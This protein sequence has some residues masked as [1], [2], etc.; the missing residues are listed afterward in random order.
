MTVVVVASGTAAVVAETTATALG[1][2]GTAGV[3]SSGKQG[4]SSGSSGKSSPEITAAET[5]KIKAAFDEHIPDFK[6]ELEEFEDIYLDV[7][8]TMKN[9]MNI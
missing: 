8:K 2:A 5:T 7:Y 1:V 6:K 9:R 3:A 4:S